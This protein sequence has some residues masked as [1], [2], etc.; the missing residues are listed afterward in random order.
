[1]SSSFVEKSSGNYPISLT[2]DIP[3]IKKFKGFNLDAI[4]LSFL[5]RQSLFV[6]SVI[7]IAKMGSVNILPSDLQTSYT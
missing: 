4:C 2:M 1:M 7:N 6:K 5:S 3:A